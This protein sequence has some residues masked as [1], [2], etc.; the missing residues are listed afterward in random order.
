VNGFAQCG[1]DRA[2]LRGVADQFFP[3]I[4]QYKK[5]ERFFRKEMVFNDLDRDSDI[6]LIGFA[7]LALPPV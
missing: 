1:I 6:G 5:M 3:V 2:I 4:G 7:A